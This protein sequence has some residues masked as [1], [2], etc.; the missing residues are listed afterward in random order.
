MSQLMEASLADSLEDKLPDQYE[1]YF[2]PLLKS[3]KRVNLTV[4]ETMHV[5]EATIPD[6]EDH[7]SNCTGMMTSEK[8][9]T[10]GLY[11]GD[12]RLLQKTYKVMY[13]SK[14]AVFDDEYTFA[15]L[16]TK[17]YTLEYGSNRYATAIKGRSPKNRWIMARWCGATE[18]ESNP[19][20]RPGYILYFLKHSVLELATEEMHFHYFA[21]VTW[22]KPWPL[23]TCYIH[24]L[25]RW[26]KDDF[27]PKSWASYIPV[28]RIQ[29]P[30]GR[31]TK[32]DHIVVAP[33]PTKLYL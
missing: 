25:T 31:I 11:P 10:T 28:S 19:T 22:Y 27:E 18:I 12:K 8:T 1:T 29:C 14:A 15:D 20:P 24:P 21:R 3:M 32:E 5:P 9:N 17:S 7:W 23:P 6:C 4:C 33:L 16:Y 2:S 26:K 13:L 30:F